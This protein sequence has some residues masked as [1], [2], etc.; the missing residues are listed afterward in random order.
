[1]STYLGKF[2]NDPCWAMELLSFSSSSSST[3]MFS[4][5]SSSTTFLSIFGEVEVRLRDSGLCCFGGE[6]EVIVVVIVDIGG[7][8]DDD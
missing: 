1:M 3:L 2:S 4:S 5:S 8:T 7:K 6:E